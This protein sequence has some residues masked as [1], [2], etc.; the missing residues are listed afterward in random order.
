[1]VDLGRSEVTAPW[2]WK[3][4]NAYRMDSDQKTWFAD[5]VQAQIDDLQASGIG[6]AGLLIDPIFAPTGVAVYADKDGSPLT[7]CS[8]KRP[9]S[10][11]RAARTC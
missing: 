6:F 11:C 8:V 7:V 10:S 1:M 4:P 2:V 3:T 9:S 5:H